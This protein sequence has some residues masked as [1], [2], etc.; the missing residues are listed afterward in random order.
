MLINILRGPSRLPPDVTADS[1]PANGSREKVRSSLRTF[2]EEESAPDHSANFTGGRKLAEQP[3]RSR[4]GIG[5]MEP[6][7]TMIEF[8]R[9]II[10]C[11]IYH[12][13]PAS[14]DSD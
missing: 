14:L 8:K 7:R 9:F 3:A 10:E 6:E 4:P 1:E 5:D 13:I 11:A 12:R 2:D